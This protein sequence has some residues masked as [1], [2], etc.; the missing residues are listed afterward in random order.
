MEKTYNN[1][2][3]DVLLQ[4]LSFLKDAKISMIVAVSI[5]W[6]A[7]IG[8]IAMIY[9]SMTF[10]GVLVCLLM[11]L[12]CIAGTIFTRISCVINSMITKHNYSVNKTQIRKTSRMSGE[13]TKG[14]SWY[15]VV[16]I[17][18]V[19]TNFLPLDLDV[20]SIAEGE[21]IDVDFLRH[22]KKSHYHFVIASISE[23]EYENSISNNN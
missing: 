12:P 9:F 23:T 8:G 20:D 1:H 13:A 5:L 11:L 6:L 16:T 3:K 22:T 18:G 17:D 4:K 14:S 10:W 2:E 21:L 15:E 19:K 7:F